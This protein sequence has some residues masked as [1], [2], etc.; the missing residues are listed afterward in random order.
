MILINCA[1]RQDEVIKMVEDMEIDGQ[2]HF[3]FKNKQGLKLHFDST[4]DDDSK[5]AK[6]I[7]SHIKSTP[8]GQALFF[9]VNAE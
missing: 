3:K 4:Y 8:L 9:S 1:L 7:K 6:L 5:A 2:K